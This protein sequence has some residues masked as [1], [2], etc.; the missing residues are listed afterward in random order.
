MAERPGV[1]GTYIGFI[2]R[3]DNVPTLTIV[4]QI[5]A[6]LRVRPADLLRDF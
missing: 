3:G 1:S 6:A 4:L 5:A 2:E